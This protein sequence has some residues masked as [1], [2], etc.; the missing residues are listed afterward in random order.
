[1][2]YRHRREKEKQL[3]SCSHSTGVTGYIGGDIFAELHGQHPEYTYSALVR[4]SEKGKTITATYPNVRIVEGSLGDLEVLKREAAS[5]DIVIRKS[6]LSK[7]LAQML[8]HIHK[9]PQTRQTMP[10]QRVQLLPGSYQD[11]HD[12]TPATISIPAAQAS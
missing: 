12:K 2:T 11:T 9:T 7:Q 5:S 1:M 8:I 10:Q 6:I 4:S 3:T